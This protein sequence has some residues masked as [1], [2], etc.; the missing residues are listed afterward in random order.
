MTNISVLISI[1][2]KEHAEY[3]NQCLESL[4]TQTVPATEIIIVKDGTLT[5]ELENILSVSKEKLPLKIVGYKEN[6]GLA[7]ALQYGLKFC[8]YELI[9]RMD[10]DDICIPDR[11]EKQIKYFNKNINIDIAG[12]YISEFID[13]IENNVGIRDVPLNDIEIK[14]YLKKRSPFNHVTVMF[15]KDAVLKSGNYQDW[16]L[17]EDSYLWCRMLLNN[18]KF[19]NINDI[20]VCVRVGKDM[21]NRRGGWEYYNS[22]I[23]LQ[24]FMLKNKLIN[25]HEYI[26]IVF[27]KFVVQILIPNNI[28]KFIYL[29]FLRKKQLKNNQ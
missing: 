6:R 16:Y 25:I 11:F 23:R 2:Y 20:L 19:G 5:D 15:K 13:T 4:A 29:H 7:Y 27:I 10:S 18:C 28:R 8:S 14:N 9:A 17:Y 26:I 24:K 22:G 12:G 21:Y 3:L 1:Y